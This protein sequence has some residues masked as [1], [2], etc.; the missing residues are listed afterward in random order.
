MTG[1]PSPKTRRFTGS[2]CDWIESYSILSQNTSA[3]KHTGR[4][5]LSVHCRHSQRRLCVV[6]CRDQVCHRP[7]IDQLRVG[8]RDTDMLSIARPVGSTYLLYC[9]SSCL[10]MNR[11]SCLHGSLSSRPRRAAAEVRL[12]DQKQ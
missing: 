11:S 8:S 10:R 1:S 3:M 5:D 7:H 12:S 9:C 4:F 6:E 2:S